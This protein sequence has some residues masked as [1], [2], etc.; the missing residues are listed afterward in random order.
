MNQATKTLKIDFFVHRYG[1]DSPK[2][3]EGKAHVDKT[4]DYIFFVS[5]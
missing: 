2:I 5:Q 4:G 1:C 3:K